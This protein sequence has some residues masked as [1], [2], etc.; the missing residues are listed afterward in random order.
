MST[1]TIKESKVATENAAITPPLEKSAS[2]LAPHQ[3]TLKLEV[4]F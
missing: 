4:N 3:G 1:H 2:E